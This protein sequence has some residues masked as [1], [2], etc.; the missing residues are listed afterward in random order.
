MWSTAKDFRD[1]LRRHVSPIASDPSAQGPA[2]GRQG[3]AAADF[4]SWEC[5][6][7]TSKFETRFETLLRGDLTGRGGAH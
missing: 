4:E 5:L 6:G 2:R 1:L 7:K 3:R